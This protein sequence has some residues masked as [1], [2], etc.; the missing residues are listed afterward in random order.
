MTATIVEQLNRVAPTWRRAPHPGI[1][2]ALAVGAVGFTVAVQHPIGIATTAGFGAVVVA[3]WTGGWLDSMPARRLTLAAVAP[4]LML[5][6]RASLWL[7]P[8]NLVAVA[9]LLL[10]AA[11]A[12]AEDRSV[13]DALRR[14]VHVPSL[15]APAAW[16]VD[17]A[18]RSALAV[19][20]RAGA[21]RRLL[22]V[23]RGVAIATPIAITLIALLTAADALFQSAITISIDGPL[24]ARNLAFLLVGTIAMGALAGHGTWPHA[25]RS[26]RLYLRF[27]GLELGI[28]LASVAA[29]YTAFVTSQVV[30]LTAGAAYVERSTGLTYAEYARQGFFQLLAA[31]ALTV[32]VIWVVDRRRRL[33]RSWS[34]RRL[35]GL[36]LLIVALTIVVVLVAIRRLFL[37]EAEFGLTML[38][39]STIVFAAWI[40]VVLV[41][42][43]LH[44]GDRLHVD[45]VA[46]ALG[47]AL[48]T[49]LAVNVANPEAIVAHRNIDRFG[50]SGALDVSYLADHLGPDAYAAIVSDPDARDWLCRVADRPDDRWFVFNLG[51]QRGARALTD[52]CLVETE[53]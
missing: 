31:A 14:V 27:G 3:S 32:T 30:A 10:L 5:S 47:A 22:E 21:S 46:A 18:S 35:L 37:Y 19:P 13:I 26:P 28:V 52:V 42:F 12:R 41:L 45:V 23:G 7:V 15:L 2:V 33:L 38:R 29:V 36:E 51:R 20:R 17:L 34:Q 11:V 8:L 48:L 40:G 1:L 43:A 24:L 9:G 44:L 4:A 16:S 53:V 25:S 6:V 49:L 39:F 50:G